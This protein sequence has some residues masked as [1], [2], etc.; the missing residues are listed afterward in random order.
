MTSLLYQVLVEYLVFWDTIHFRPFP[1]L[2]DSDND[3]N[4]QTAPE[5]QFTLEKTF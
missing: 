5:L 4:T 1:P 3:N 2:P